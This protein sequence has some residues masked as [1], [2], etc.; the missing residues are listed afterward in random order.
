MVFCVELNNCCSQILGKRPL[1]A[2]KADIFARLLE[3][4]TNPVLAMTTCLAMLMV[5]R[6]WRA[7]SVSEEC[8]ATLENSAAAVVCFQEGSGE[9]DRR[10]HL[11]ELAAELTA[12]SHSLLQ[13]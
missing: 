6:M 10:S 4:Q 3:F 13:R 7:W 11:A 1:A 8:V 12:Y 2:G 5:W 9:I